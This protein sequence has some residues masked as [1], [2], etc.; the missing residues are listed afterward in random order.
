M[1]FQRDSDRHVRRSPGP[2]WGRFSNLP[3]TSARPSTFS[4]LRGSLAVVVAVAFGSTIAALALT[5]VFWQFLHPTP[6]LLGFGAAILSARVGGRA[7]GFLAVGLG[8]IVYAVFP[9][10]LP[11][12]RIGRLLFGFVVISATFSWFVAR[13][14]EVE[15]QLATSQRHLQAMMSSM[16][17]LLWVVDRAGRV[18]AADG[19][20]LDVLN[21]KPRELIG[22]SLF[23]LYHDVPDNV[24]NLQ[25]AMAGETFSAIA[26]IGN[27]D[28]ETW[29]SPSRDER[30]AVTG[31]I[32]ISI[33]VT[34]RRRLERQY[35]QL[36]KMEA[37]GQLAA[38]I[39][40]DFNNLLVAIGGYVELVVGTLDVSDARREDLVEVRKAAQRAALLTRQLLA[41]SRRQV[42]H[43][44]VLDL[45]LLVAN[46]QRLLRRALREDIHLVL[47]LDAIG[48]IRAD[49]AELEHALLNLAV[50][51]GDAMPDGGE[52]SFTTAS[53]DVD[54]RLAAEMT[55]MMPGRYVRLAVADT[56]CGMTLE[57]QAHIF[58][59]FF[60]TKE[61]SKGSGLGLATVDGIV[62]QSGGFIRVASQLGH[63]TTFELYF[64]VVDEAL[65]R[66]DETE[67][68][69]SP[70]G[71]SES[72]LL[73]EDDGAVRRLARDVLTRWGYVV[74]EARDGDEA[75][76]VAGNQKGAIHLL[77]T[78]VV[79]P[80][81]G[82]RALAA[83]LTERHPA[84]RVLYTSG[85][86]NDETLCATVERGLAF[87]SKPFLPVD[88]VRC[89]REV[90]DA[91]PAAAEKVEK[92]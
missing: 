79:M 39:A 77:I 66:D 61:R 52:L 78:D 35:L 68:A 57:T 59:P 89:V 29:Y 8:A 76:A 24:A 41:F 49:P 71:G 64:P 50:N 84:L 17:V 45:N 28:V 27:G 82:G 48:P 33:D 19:S 12:D 21:L 25:R 73:A 81:L 72:I 56:G 74:L 32:G 13:R 42:L 15:A 92:R 55:P 83:K 22:R 85:Y 10:P 6:F 46:V 37:V 23:E 65:D 67:P 31:A 1:P 44:K 2:L 62:R 38:G 63:G 53:I 69:G 47:N 3:R 16:P 88:L 4:R 58:E 51:A 54:D 20:G 87:L 43:P 18:T 75:L 14:Y 11:P 9:P 86:A 26:P 90:L 36:Q 70:Q 5:H 91:P 7:G 60:T 34:A 80:G 40:H 30:G